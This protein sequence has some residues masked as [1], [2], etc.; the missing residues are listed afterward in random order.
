MCFTNLESEITEYYT[1]ATRRFKKCDNGKSGCVGNRLCI[2]FILGMRPQPSP[3]A[4]PVPGD[5]GGGDGGAQTHGDKG[6]G[7][8]E[9]E[10]VATAEG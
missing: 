2:S 5:G 9:K 1:I 3:L 4:P 6:D 7:G 10:A 8:A